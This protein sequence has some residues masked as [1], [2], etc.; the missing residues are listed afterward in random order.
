[1]QIFS[2]SKASFL[3]SLVLA[4]VPFAYAQGAADSQPSR[5]TRIRV[6][7]GVIVGL[8]EHEE[9]PA[10]PNKS[11]LSG[12][13]GEVIF[14][15]LVNEEGKIVSVNVVEGDPLLTAASADALRKFRFRPYLLNGAPIQVESQLEYKFSLKGKGADAKGKLNMFQT[16]H[17]VPNFAQV[18][19]QQVVFSYCGHDRYLALNRNWAKFGTIW[20]V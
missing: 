1:M 4:W 17:I 18:R 5:P 16:F 3:L 7:S 11:L 2:K 13:Q 8:V 6:S 12:T 9:L 15:I 10:Y 14:K 19:L 20:N